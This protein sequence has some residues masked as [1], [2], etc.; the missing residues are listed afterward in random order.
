MSRSLTEPV[1]P[2]QAGAPVYWRGLGG[3]A[4]ALAVAELAARRRG[5]ILVIA[6]DAQNAERLESE[7]KFYSRHAAPVLRFPDWE[8]LP[9][10]I[11]SPQQDLVS[12]RLEALYRLPGLDHGVAVVPV[13]TLIQRLPP[14]H[15]VGA[16]SLLLRIG[17]RLDL[18]QMRERLQGFGYSYATQVTEHG[19]F[20]VRG[21]LLDIFPWAARSPIASTCS[22][23]RWNPSD[24]RSGQPTLR[25]QGRP[26][27]HPARARIPAGRGRHQDL[28]PPLPR[29]LRRQPA[30]EPDLPRRQQ[31]AGAQRHRVLPAAVLRGHRHAVR[32]PAA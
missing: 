31:R 15:Y 3:S 12:R 30:E 4:L 22:M 14:R 5:L 28:P 16:Y 17:E 26:H 20:A 27:P 10:D 2:A 29:A 18:E 9:F 19:E 23:T 21:S 13:N 25:R 11:F 6:D 7:I 24:L 1:V 32:L 8:T